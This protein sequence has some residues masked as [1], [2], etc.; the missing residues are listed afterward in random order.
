[1]LTVVTPVW[2]LRKLVSTSPEERTWCQLAWLKAHQNA[3]CAAKPKYV[4]STHDCRWRIVQ[5]AV[6]RIYLSEKWI[7]DFD[8]LSRRKRE[9]QEVV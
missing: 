3:V 4:S 9:T 8:I 1:M 2:L 6:G 5:E 7:V